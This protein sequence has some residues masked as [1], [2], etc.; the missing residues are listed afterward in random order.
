MENITSGDGM[1]KEDVFRIALATVNKTQKQVAKEC[2]V[3]ENTITRIK[4]GTEP[5]V[6]LARKI[7]RAVNRTVEE[8][9]SLDD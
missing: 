3:T 4:T 8:L 1:F 9:W 6:Y 7:A 5:G 2:R